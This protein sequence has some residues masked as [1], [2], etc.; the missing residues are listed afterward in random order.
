VRLED[1][2]DVLGGARPVGSGPGPK[3]QVDPRA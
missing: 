2:G 1:V 3:I